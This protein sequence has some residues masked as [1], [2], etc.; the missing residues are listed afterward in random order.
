MEF[1]RSAEKLIEKYVNRKANSKEIEVLESWY[2]RYQTGDTLSKQELQEEY[3]I[4]LRK[5]NIHL[6]GI[7]KSNSLWQRV[8]S[9]AAVAFVLCAGIYFYTHPDKG[10]KEKI[11]VAQDIPPG[12][13]TAIITLASGE[14]I[15]LSGSKKGVVIAA[16]KLVYNDGTTVPGSLL[17]KDV[18]MTAH[19]PRGAIYNL[20]LP[21]GT[22]VIMNAE[23]SLKF[24][25]CEM[26]EKQA[27]AGNQNR[28]RRVSIQDSSQA[29]HSGG[30]PAEGD[31]RLYRSAIVSFCVAMPDSFRLR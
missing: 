27:S 19:T 1:K 8:A 24:R 15:N 30:L 21:D 17:N 12:K 25:K 16:N 23:S 10:I 31:I 6:N 29:S 5:L 11:S 14:T 2:L 9:A 22:M 7:Q 28:P 4:G 13:N 26:F 20:T 3:E 18:Q